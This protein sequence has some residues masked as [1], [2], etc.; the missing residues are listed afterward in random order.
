MNIIYFLLLG[1]FWGGSFLGISES[2]K[3]FSP[4]FAVTLRI[5]IAVIFSGLYL[6][7]KKPVFP[8]KK[9]I[10]LATFNGIVGLGI[11]WALLFWGEQ[12]VTPALSS[13]INSTSTIFTVIFAAFMLKNTPDR[14]T[15]NKTLGIIIGF[16][17]IAVIFGPF[18]SAKSAKSIEG[19][20]AILLM[21]V[22]YG[23]SI[24]FLKIFADK[25]SCMMI[26]FF[27]AV[28]GLIIIVP[29]ALIDGFNN[30]FVVPE[31]LFRSTVAILYLG[32]F[33]T[34][35]AMLLFYKLLK[36]VGSI[37]AAAVTYIVPIVSI[38]LDW[39][40][41][42]KWIGNHALFGAL[43]VFAALRMINRPESKGQA[44]T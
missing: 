30:Y 28:G 20:A 29:I 18:V 15:W 33:S 34:S 3:G 23:F 1:L 26:L 32:I 16:I 10:L 39:F 2:I 5:A 43:I 11:P 6:L 40:V 14:I 41:L 8:A 21:A 42:D 35:I 13:I 7:I 4:F 31:F 9:Y 25:L 38:A 12:Y 44:I 22:L 36:N 37:Q 27:E 17:G 19:L 24:A